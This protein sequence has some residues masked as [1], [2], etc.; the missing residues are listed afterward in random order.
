MKRHRMPRPIPGVLHMKWANEGEAR[1]WNRHDPSLRG[2][3]AWAWGEGCSKA[4]GA[5]MHSVMCTG[6]WS[7]TLRR[8]EPSLMEELVKRGYDLTTLRF[9]IRKKVNS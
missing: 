9:S 6:P 4:D 2:D 8:C 5:L 1:G 3:V 7:I